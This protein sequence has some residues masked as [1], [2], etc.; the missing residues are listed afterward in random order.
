MIVI[1]AALLLGIVAG[2][3]AMTAPAVLAWAA[4]LGWMRSLGGE[5]G[6]FVTV[7]RRPA[8]TATASARTEDRSSSWQDRAQW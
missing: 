6:L 1:I 7:G 5:G 8:P 2:L 3:R 4:Q